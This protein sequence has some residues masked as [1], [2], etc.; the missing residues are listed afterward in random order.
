MATILEVAH[1]YKGDATWGWVADLLDN[2]I[3]V[4]HT[5]AVIWGLN[6]NTSEQSIQQGMTIADA[7]T[8]TDANGFYEFTGLRPGSYTTSETQPAG[9]LD[10][11]DTAG[12]A[13]GSTA[14]NDVISA[15]T[16]ASG[17]D[18]LDDLRRHGFG[19]RN[20][21]DIIGRALAIGGG[22]RNV[23]PDCGKPFNG[24][25][26]SSPL[27]LT[28]KPN[29]CPSPA[30]PCPARPSGLR[31]LSEDPEDPEIPD[32]NHAIRAV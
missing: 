16:L 4:A 5:V 14:V 30:E 6:Y 8:A 22:G 3:T 21:G 15:V 18:G 25:V 12:T 9:Y 26:H 17:E 7:V 32:E 31:G 2:K 20:K 23:R 13:G 1:T 24:V 10:G 29:S 19:H 11:K 27:L 28:G